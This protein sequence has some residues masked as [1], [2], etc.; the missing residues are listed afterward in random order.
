MEHISQP[1]IDA[2]EGFVTYAMISDT[3]NVMNAIARSTKGLLTRKVTCFL[4]GQEP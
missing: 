2:V 3:A 1:E 4:R